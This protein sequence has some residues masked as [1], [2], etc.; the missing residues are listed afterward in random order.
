M[1]SRFLTWLPLVV[2]LTWSIGALPQ[3]GVASQGKTHAPACA[4]AFGG[5]ELINPPDVDVWTLP[6]NASGEHELI[7][8]VHGDE[9]RYCYRYA[10]DGA[11]QDVAPTIRVRRG[12]HFA[13][14]IVN[15]IV[16]PSPGEKVSSADIPPCR[17]ADMPMR[18]TTHY[19]G[20]LNHTIDDRYM[21]VPPVDTNLHLHGFEGPASEENTFLSTLS[22]PMHACEYHVTIP[23]TQPPGTYMYHP[24]SHGAS[25]S[26]VALGLDGAWIVEPDQPQLPRSAEHVLFLRYRLPIAFDNM[27]APDTNPFVPVAA[28]REAARPAAS[29]VPYDP[30]DPP[31]WPMVY[32]M[33][34]GDVALDPSGCN[35]SSSEPFMQVD[36]AEAPALLRL[37]AGSTQLLRI[38]DG[39]SD[40]AAALQL[41]D[42]S[43]RSQ[44]LRVVAIDGVPV[45]GDMDHPL[46]HYIAM[47]R[48]MLS[49]MSRADVLVTMQA[50]ETLTLSKEHYCQGKDGFYQL[51]HDLVN[52]SAGA[53]H[54][55]AERDV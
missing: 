41:R 50:G 6:L 55:G 5:R 16:G 9:N 1:S 32:P 33:K 21:K 26:E 24:H 35:G 43:G 36:Q 7:L 17:P 22:T 18:A 49:S 2:A 25:D 10:I 37:P 44:P 12:E 38:V 28:A 42:S 51:R 45:S 8:A 52:I 14:R 23:R 29:P 27:Y 34:L 15:D 47:K 11:V 19:V 30:F 46:S 13:V 39:T 4:P 54:R 48:V 53:G 31:P 20:Y 40:S 3:A